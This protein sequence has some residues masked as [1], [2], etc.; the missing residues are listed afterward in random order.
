MIGLRV[1]RPCIK[2]VNETSYIYKPA[3]G[4]RSLMPLFEDP[5]V[6]R[7]VD[8]LMHVMTWFGTFLTCNPVEDWLDHSRLKEEENHTPFVYVNDPSSIHNAQ[9]SFIKRY[10][11]P[12]ALPA[13]EFHP[14]EEQVYSLKCTKSADSQSMVGC[15]VTACPPGDIEINRTFIS[16]W[17][18]FLLIRAHDLPRLRMFLFN[19]LIRLNDGSSHRMVLQDGFRG[20]A[21]DA[22]FKISD[23]IN[24]VGS[25]KPS[26]VLLDLNGAAVTVFDV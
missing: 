26:K 11:A 23:I 21:G 14:V 5:A 17:E 22:I 13:V 6:T 16:S 19:K 7:D 1:N 18:M 9:S 2:L 20:R 4:T 10:I 25:D 24:F 12:R 15:Y 8:S 3:I